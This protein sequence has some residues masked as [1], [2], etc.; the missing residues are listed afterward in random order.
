MA[1]RFALLILLLLAA[2]RLVADDWPQWRGPGRDGVWRESG[3]VDRFAASELRRKW[4]AP[5]GPGYSGPT[6]AAGRVFVTDRLVEPKQVERVHAFDAQTGQPLWLYSYDCTYKISYEAGPRASVAID[7]GRAYSL[8]AMGHLVCLDARSGKVLWRKEPDRDY[9]L[10]VPIWGIAA[11]P[12]VEGDLVIVQLGAKE[13]CLA[14]FDKR[15]GE[16]RWQALSDRASYSAP[17]VIEQAGRRVLVCWTGDNVVGLNPA[18]GQVY[19]RHE[20]KPT[21]MVI[22]IATPVVDGDRL[23]VTSFYDGSLMLKLASD[24]PAVEQLWRRAGPDE[25]HTDG[26]HSIIS[27]PLLLGDYVYGVDSYGELR[28]LRAASGERVWEDLTATPKNRWSNIHLVRS[29][30][31]RIWMFNELGELIIGR[32]SPR[33]FAEISRAKLIEPTR[34]QLDR[35]GKGVCWSHPAYAGR[36]VFARN[37]RELVAAS[38]VAGEN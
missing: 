7:Q 14:A 19:W 27:T 34:T 11:S 32:L 20:F 35:R 26:L 28:C 6:V 33:G 23:L 1:R 18:N 5:V 8:G 30:D 3:L 38:L 2:E 25:Q 21:R 29:A 12:L 36:H 16:P 22:G 4:S 37:D 17:I 9:Q 31:E 10:N 24:A 13:G 15:S